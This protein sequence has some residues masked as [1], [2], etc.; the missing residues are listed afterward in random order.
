MIYKFKDWTPKIGERSWI[1]PSADVIG[2]VELGED[3]SVWFGAVLRG[4]IHYIKIGKGTNIQ[5]LA[6]IH[7]THFTKPD[8]SDGNPTILG[9]YVTIGHKVMLHG[10]TIGNYSLIGMNA[11]VL[12]GA[13]IGEESIV[14]AGA[15][16]TMNKKFPS[17]S[18]I[19]GSPA[20]VVRQLSDEEVQG[21]HDHSEHYV[22]F[23]D[24]Y[25]AGECKVVEIAGGKS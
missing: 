19:I 20:K 18:L 5:D 8:M 7:T 15:L 12:D 24:D 17:R 10:C 4:D 11:V 23:K 21:L 9:D 25:L 14:G 2:F 22:R 6:M 3:C 13:E 16:V 1:A